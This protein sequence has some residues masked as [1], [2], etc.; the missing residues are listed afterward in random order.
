M[1]VVVTCLGFGMR[2]PRKS[3]LVGMENQ[4]T[5]R[6]SHV[7]WSNECI[8]IFAAVVI[9]ISIFVKAL[10]I[11]LFVNICKIP[12]YSGRLH[13]YLNKDRNKRSTTCSGNKQTNKP[14]NHLIFLFDNT[15]LGCKR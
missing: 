6:V 1:G 2:N 8:I 5:D 13:K 7:R 4:Y 9:I 10:L 12:K 11:L 14:T 3:F 15:C